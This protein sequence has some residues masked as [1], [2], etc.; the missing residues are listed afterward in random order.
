[1]IAYDFQFTEQ[2]NP[3]D[4]GD[5]LDAVANAGNLVL[6]TA[7]ADR[8]RTKI[9]GGNDTL[10]RL[11]AIPSS[12]NTPA[13]GTRGGVYRR[14]PFEDQGLKGVAVAT[15]ERA[16]GRPVDRSRFAGDGAWIDF[17]GP[18]GTIPA[19]PFSDL[20][21]GRVPPSKIRGKVVVVGAVDPILQD[22]HAAATGANMAGPEINANA[23]ATIL[24]G[25]P[26][27]DA[28]TWLSVLLIA[29]AALLTPAAALRLPGLRWLPVP[30][31]LAVAL[32]VGAQLAFDGGTIVPVVAP[33]VTLLVA[34]LGTLAV[35]YAIDVRERR[36]LRTAFARFVPSDVVDEVVEGVGDEL[37]LGGTRRDSTVLF[38]DLRAFTRAAETLPAERVIER[39][40]FAVPLASQL[41]ISGLHPP[42]FFSGS[43][44]A[45]GWP[46]AT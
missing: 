34:F 42:H 44:V 35:A 32:P 11:H 15:A 33:A 26:L 28:A 13:S 30:L 4:D 41:R 21:A 31:V 23:I 16:T 19:I 27:R 40:A 8:G 2:T 9:L 38:C 10:R 20:I 36:Y 29:L 24:N 12:S 1:M 43:P 14:I 3:R 18:P 45:H 5:L 25:F 39:R 17:A 46:P 37:R 22:V 6:V 7:V